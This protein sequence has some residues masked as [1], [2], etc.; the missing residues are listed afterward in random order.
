MTARRIAVAATAIALLASACN[1]SPVR[2]A[3]DLRCSLPVRVGD[4][5]GFVD[6]PSGRF[7]ADPSAPAPEPVAGFMYAHGA[8]RWVK[9]T[10]AF[11]EYQMSPD[12]TE[13]AELERPT[14]SDRFPTGVSLRDL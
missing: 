14:G 5:L 2:S 8:H 12:G 1:N 3:A 13:L 9:V 4:E 6:F 10:Y 7:R 11:A